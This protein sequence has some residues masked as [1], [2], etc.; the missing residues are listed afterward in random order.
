MFK[1]KKEID[2]INKEKSHSFLG[3][4]LLQ[5]TVNCT[6]SNRGQMFSG[7][8]LQCIQIENAEPPLVFT[9]F[10]NQFGDYSSYG[11]KRLDG[12]FEVIKKFYKNKYNY[13]LLVKNVKTGEYDVV[14]RNECKHLTEKYGYHNKNDVIDSL[15][16]G[17]IIEDEVLYRNNNYDDDMN[18]QYGT[19]LNTLFMSYGGYTNEDAVVIS[20]S[21]A[22]KMA[23]PFVNVI[24]IPLNT[25]DILINSLGNNDYYKCFPD[26]G[27]KLDNSGIVCSSRRINYDDVAVTLKNMRSRLNSDTSYYIHES[28][29]SKI[30]DINVFCNENDK[31]KTFNELYNKQIGK[32]YYE[33]QKYYTEFYE[34]M[35]PIVEGK[36]KKVSHKFTKELLY[37]YNRYKMLIDPNVRLKCDGTLFDHIILQLVVLTRSPLCVGSK[38]AGR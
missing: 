9:D 33:N 7:M 36:S 23:A 12:E 11:Y 13:L 35:K 17:D 22:E 38:L 21:T 1:D 37:I 20:K 34:F 6:D 27:E 10:E 4:L 5:P 19:N 15:Q 14:F 8:I 16:T 3:N 31:E 30:V 18:F 26:I 24:N 25:N 28:E 32:Y 29:N 2:K